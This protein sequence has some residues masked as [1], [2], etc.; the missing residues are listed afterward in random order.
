M[1]TNFLANG[2]RPLNVKG[3]CSVNVKLGNQLRKN[4]TL[5]VVNLNGSNLLGLDWRDA[6][7][8][9]SQ[10]MPVFKNVH[11]TNCII[12]SDKNISSLREKFSDV[13]SKNW[14]NVG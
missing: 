6:F 12:L 8:F 4:M 14:E 7:G 3:Q 11:A 10:G 2:G 5:I 9:T 13:F 1:E